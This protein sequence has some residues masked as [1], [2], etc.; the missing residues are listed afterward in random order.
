[1]T[2]LEE[3]AHEYLYNLNSIT[4]KIHQD[5][6]ILQKNHNEDWEDLDFDK[7]EVLL[8]NFFVDGTVKQ[9]YAVDS[10][11]NEKEIACFPKYTVNC[12]EKIVIDF[13]NDVSVKLPVF[14]KKGIEILGLQH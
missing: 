8:D 13:D 6:Q 11:D 9:K 10:T 12:G 2:T 7:Q 3:H 14:S 5:I 4:R 1:M